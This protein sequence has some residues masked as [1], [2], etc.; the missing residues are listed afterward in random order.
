[1]SEVQAHWYL[2]GSPADWD[3]AGYVRAVEHDHAVFR[4]ITEFVSF[5]REEVMVVCWKAG[6]STGARYEAVRDGTRN[7]RPVW[8]FRWTDDWR[9]P[10]WYAEADAPSLTS[11]DKTDTDAFIPYEAPRI[12]ILG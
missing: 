1:M 2:V 7:G 6:H 8:L 9:R 3:R 11:C 4:Y 10:E 12:D 5:D